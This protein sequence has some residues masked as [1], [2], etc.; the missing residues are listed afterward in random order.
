MNHGTYNHTTEDIQERTSL[1]RH[2]INKCSSKLSDL[3]DPYRQYGENNQLFYDDNGLMVFDHIGQLKREG[4][5]I[6]QIR[7]TLENELQNQQDDAKAD[8]KSS[9][10]GSKNRNSETG[11]SAAEGGLQSQLIEALQE[12]NREIRKA[13]DEVIESQKE[14]IDSLRQNVKLITD[15]RDPETV[16]QEHEQKVKEAAEKEQEIR[17]LRKEK[18]RQ[19]RRRHQREQRRKELLA[20]LKSLEGKWF[21]SSRRQE[22]IAEL[23]RLDQLDA[24]D[25]TVGGKGS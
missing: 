22:I 19:K 7:E 4:K 12:S 17:E 3:L 8:R 23:E 10:N 15:G 9:Q 20:E 13:K 1:P 5:T 24:Q 16:K 21:K 11:H 25:E 14:T 2:F 6:P 18:E